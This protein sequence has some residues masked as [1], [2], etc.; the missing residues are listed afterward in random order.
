[1]NKQSLGTSKPKGLNS[2]LAKIW[3]RLPMP[4]GDLP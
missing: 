1:M 2:R 3:L 4:E